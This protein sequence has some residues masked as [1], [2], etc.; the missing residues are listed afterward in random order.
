MR[1]LAL[2][3]SALG[4]TLSVVPRVSLGIDTSL[5]DDTYLMTGS[6]P[7]SLDAGRLLG[8]PSGRSAPFTRWKSAKRH[9]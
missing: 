9:H 5:T 1:R 7:A 6:D 3:L 4:V 8:C 2:V